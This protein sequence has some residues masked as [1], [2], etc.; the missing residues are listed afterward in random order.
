[1]WYLGGSCNRLV[2]CASVGVPLLGVVGVENDTE[3]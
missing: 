1:M 3:Y 2:W